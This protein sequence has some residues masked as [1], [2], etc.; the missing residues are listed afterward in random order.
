MKVKMSFKLEQKAKLVIQ[1]KGMNISLNG[2]TA[3]LVGYGL[4]RGIV[5]SPLGQLFPK[6]EVSFSW[7]SI[8]SVI[9]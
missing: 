3:E 8:Q 7:R 1:A 2:T 9:K 5:C 4:K 6:V